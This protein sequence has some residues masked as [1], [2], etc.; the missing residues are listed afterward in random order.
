MSQAN[1]QAV[2]RLYDAF[3]DG[4]LD[5]FEQ[6]LSND[7]VWNEAENS[8]NSDGNPY[9]SFA[10]VR[11]GVFA[12]TVRDFDRFRCDLE[13][14]YDAGDNIIATG[15]YR[16]ISTATGKE[17][18][19]QFCHIAHLDDDGKL[20]RIQEYTD[21]LQEAQ[22]TGRAQQIEAIRIPQPVM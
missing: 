19:A 5:Y 10:A 9:R 16:G 2:S 18:S 4:D 11:D 20:D 15:R 13:Q 22:V 21:T 3:N 7:L 17:L 14:L 1:V 6:Q 8:L 12:P